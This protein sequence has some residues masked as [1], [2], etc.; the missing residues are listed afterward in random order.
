LTA[1]S[2]SNSFATSSLVC[3]SKPSF[4]V[5][6]TRL[7]RG[8][9]LVPACPR[10]LRHLPVR[11][12]PTIA[13]WRGRPLDASS[14][15]TGRARSCCPVPPPP[16]ASRRAGTVRRVQPGSLY[17]WVVPLTGKLTR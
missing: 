3:W 7:T 16:S 14:L 11:R 5:T 13:G 10:R 4:A 8:A 1:T 2:W 12:R 6:T 15:S 17:S 9:S